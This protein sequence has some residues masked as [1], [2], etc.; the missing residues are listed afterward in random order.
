MNKHYIVFLIISFFTFTSCDNSSENNEIKNTTILKNWEITK[1]PLGF[2]INPRDLFFINP[3]IGF[4]VGF[5]GAIYK[6]NNS[7]V[8][9]EKQDSGTDLHLNSVHFINP[10]VGFI[11]GQAMTNCL[12]KDCDKGSV[13]LKTADGGKTW[14]KKLFADYIGIKSLHFFNENKG[15]ALIYTPDLP[16]STNYHIAKTE[17]GGESWEFIN[18]AIKPVYDKFYCIDNVVFIGGENQKIYKSIDYGN[19]WQTINTPVS[20]SN[21]IRNLYFYNKT[22]GFM[23][24]VTEIYKTTDGGLNWQIVKFPFSSFGTLH[25]NSE[26]EGFNI[27]T[28]SAYKGGD[29]PTFQGSQSFQTFNSGDSWTKSELNNSIYLGL[30]CF[31]ENDL[32]YGINNSEFYTIKKK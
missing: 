4:V 16:N 31:P 22:V 3:Q 13:F 20:T 24:G 9:W 29:F 32:G 25:F 5:N 30:T 15:L 2:D 18:L 19:N 17:N 12:G 7:G 11:S 23:D 27:E 1:T 6:T 26:S 28:V 21:F 8:T 14:T 10:N